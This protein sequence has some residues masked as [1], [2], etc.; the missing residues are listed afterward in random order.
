MAAIESIG[1]ALWV[2]P[3]QLCFVFITRSILLRLAHPPPQPYLAEF[4]RPRES[5]IDSRGDV[6]L[7]ASIN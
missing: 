3:G 2:Q 4:V 7:D 1:F 6:C 5:A